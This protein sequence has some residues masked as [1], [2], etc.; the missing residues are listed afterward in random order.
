MHSYRQFLLSVYNYIMMLFW[1]KIRT[2]LLS[3]RIGK[4]FYFQI[5][6]I[7]IFAGENLLFRDQ[8]STKWGFSP[9]PL[10]KGLVLSLFRHPT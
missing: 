9:R 10:K 6:K 7:Q 8:F 1:Y 5:Q 2:N 3:Y 4:D